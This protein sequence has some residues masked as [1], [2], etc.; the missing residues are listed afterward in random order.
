MDELGADSAAGGGEVTRGFAV[1]AK[2]VF[3]LGFGFVDGGIGG[4]VDAPVGLMGGEEGVYAFGLV[5]GEGIVS[6][7]RN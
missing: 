3:F 6:G 7:K 2:S 5:D 4:A 1:D